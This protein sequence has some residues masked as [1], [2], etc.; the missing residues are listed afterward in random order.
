MEFTGPL[1]FPGI[2][3]LL[4]ALTLLVVL[5]LSGLF[6]APRAAA[7]HG[8]VARAPREQAPRAAATRP[9]LLKA[10]LSCGAILFVASCLQQTGLVF[11]TAS[12]AG[13]L[14]ALYIVLVPILGIALRHKTH[15]NTWVS[16]LIAAAGL[17]LLCVS[18][19]FSV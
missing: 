11:T 15:W 2:R 5:L 8:Q 7:A 6:S 10:G 17:Y 12:K 18:G 9:L 4:G 19:G 14:T 1:L 3:M 13:F 16:V